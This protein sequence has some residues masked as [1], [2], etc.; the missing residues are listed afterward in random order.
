MH[1][2]YTSDKPGDCPSCGMRLVP[3]YADSDGSAALTAEGTSAAIPGAVHVSPEKQ[4]LIGVRTGTVVKTSGSRTIRVLGRVAVDETR[5]YRINAAIRG[6]IR[7]IYPNTV[8]TLVRKDQP[9]ASFYAPEF[10]GPQQSYL[11]ALGAQDRFQSTGKETPEQDRQMKANMQQTIDTLR[12]MGMHDI[13]IGEMGKKRE[14]SQNIVVYSPT[15]GF[16]L[17][18]N[19]S[20]GMRFEAGTEFYQIADLS[21]VWILAD[22]FENE[23][24][25]FK[26]GASA[27]VTHPAQKL[28][29]TA[30]V[31][32]VLPQFDAATRTLKVRLEAANSDFALRPDMFVDVEYPV[33]LPAALTVPAEAVLD[34]GQRKTVFVDRGNGYFEPRRVETGWRMEDRIEITKGLMEGE[35]IVVSGNFLIDSESRLRAAAM[36]LRDNA[37]ED[38]VCGMQ[39]DPVKAG[40][41]KFTYRGATYY[42]CSDGCKEVFEKNP[43]KY[44]Q[45]ASNRK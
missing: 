12:N 37:V 26:P 35:R 23:A 19:V 11:F 29:V 34:T 20:P 5:V 2:Q 15:A 6:W 25:S 17:A 14:L 41:K 28:V 45:K 40:D 43:E 38:P 24:H 22:M 31:S 16:I 42:F 27:S 13:Q 36:G 8:G 10:I 32:D 7:E 44:A 4:Q 21:R 1:P 18:R 9:L 30:R 3:V 39:V 33:S